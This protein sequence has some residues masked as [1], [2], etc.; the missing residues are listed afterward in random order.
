MGDYASPMATPARLRRSA[1]PRSKAAGPSMHSLQ[2]SRPELHRR[3][4]LRLHRRRLHRLRLRCL[5]LRHRRCRCRCRLHLVALGGHAA[6]RRAA[7]ALGNDI[8]PPGD[9]GESPLPL[10]PLRRPHGHLP[11]ERADLPLEIAHPRLARVALRQ[12][13]DGG[14]GEQQ[15]VRGQRAELQLSR[16]QVTLRDGHLK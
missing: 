15:G 10:G 6:S 1:A 5:R 13:G 7:L 8:S 3:L 12:R 14:G 4:H 2:I 16:Q 9:W 11:A